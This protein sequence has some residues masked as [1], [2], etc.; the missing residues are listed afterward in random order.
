MLKLIVLIRPIARYL[1][2][3]W[4]LTII[5]VSS[6][7]NVPTLKIH[8]A[9][10]EFRLDYIIHFCEYGLLSFLAFLTFVRNEFMMASGK[11]FLIT[12]SLIFFA[13]LD[14]YHQKLIPGRSFSIKDILSDISGIVAVTLITIFILRALFSHVKDKKPIL[15]H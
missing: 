2:I 10:S 3:I 14:E 9:R 5:I 15:H 4:M 6:V 8:T 11:V 7:P 1:L 13:V 12:A